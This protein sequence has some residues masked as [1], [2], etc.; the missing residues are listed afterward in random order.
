[1]KDEDSLKLRLF[2]V[3][4]VLKVHVIRIKG[5]PVVVVRVATVVALVLTVAA[6]AAAVDVVTILFNDV[7]EPPTVTPL[8]PALPLA[9]PLPDML[10][11]GSCVTCSDL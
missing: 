1:M 10:G 4:W 8:A 11:A 9:L 3:T 5:V 6:V 2:C 7:P